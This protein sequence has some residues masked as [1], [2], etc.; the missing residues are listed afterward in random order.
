MH[1]SRVATV[2]IDFD[3]ESFERGAEFWSAALGRERLARSERY[4][5]LRGR[6]GGEGGP[7]IGFQRG[8]DDPQKF[9]LDI[10]TDDVEA[11]VSRLV[12]LGA[13][14]KARIRSHVVMRAPGGHTFCVV[15]AARGD[16]AAGAKTWDPVGS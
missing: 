7:Y 1:R 3:A 9:H 16:F 6:L 15:P 13:Q 11:E 2:V 12:G 14:V 10:E 5:S 8:M 4:E